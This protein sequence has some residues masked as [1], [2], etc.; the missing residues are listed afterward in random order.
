MT[1]PT[2]R[3]PEQ[4]T[5][6][7]V[8]EISEPDP[9]RNPL[10]A[11]DHL[12]HGGSYR[13]RMREAEQ[14]AA[15]RYSE[16][17]VG[18]AEGVADQAKS[19]AQRV[20]QVPWIAHLIAA[21]KRFGER[22]GSQ[23]G[24]AITYFSFLSILPLLMVGFWVLGIV[25]KGN[26]TA[27]DNVK[28]NVQQQIPG[29]FTSDIIDAAVQNGAAV[30]IVGI[31]L[32]LYS[33]VGW[34][35]NVRAAV[36]AQ[37]RPQFE[38]TEAEKRKTSFVVQWLKDLLTLVGLGVALLVSVVLTSVGG[39]AQSTV[40]GWLGLDDVGWLKPVFAVVPILLAVVADTVVFVW[41]FRMMRIPTYTPPKGAVLKGAIIAAV[42]FEVAKIAMTFLLPRMT[43]SPAFQLFGS[44]LVL[45]FFFFLVARLILFVA[46]WIG[47]APRLPEPEL[48]EV[49]GPPVLADE[50]VSRG[51]AA[52][53][54]GVGT[55]V[56]A[57][58]GYL[59]GERI[60]DRHRKRLLATLR[61]TGKVSPTRL[62][63]AARSWRGITK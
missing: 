53:L 50:D 54:V 11:E 10:T 24:A 17:L 27:I 47:T 59:A 6:V 63:K 21:G 2:R 60:P 20:Q 29:T 38:K 23:F 45:L 57:T 25:L 16:E 37:W 61:P 18:D 19:F 44:I 36:Q 46:A 1:A 32:A 33:G 4:D 5:A 22:L 49:P 30:G 58:A 40:L 56:G 51:T 42:G 15:V 35:S 43:K 14:G 62:V 9:T 55:A 28:E 41:F 13:D 3:R 7:A 12:A 39:A 26:Q 48:P 31:V 52:A 8:V 34:M